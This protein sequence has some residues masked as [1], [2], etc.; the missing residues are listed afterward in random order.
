R[1]TSSVSCSNPG[2]PLSCPLSLHDAL[3]IYVRV[4]A[5]GAPVFLS[6]S[7]V[8]EVAG[9]PPQQAGLSEVGLREIRVKAQRFLRGHLGSFKRRDRKS[10][11]LNSSHVAIS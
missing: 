4:E 2:T 8:E 7:L 11:R 1:T 9:W 5:Q 6:R 3:P 10:T